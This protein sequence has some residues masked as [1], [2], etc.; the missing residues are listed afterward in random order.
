[1]GSCVLAWCG[2]NAEAITM[3]RDSVIYNRDKGSPRGL[4]SNRQAFTALSSRF[5]QLPQHADGLR[6]V[7]I[8][9]AAGE[10]ELDVSRPPDATEVR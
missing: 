4:I 5:A 2:R 7:E 8:L 1:M 3:L 9:L 6:E 10:R